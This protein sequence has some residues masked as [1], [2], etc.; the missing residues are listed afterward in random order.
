MRNIN[1]AVKD[2]AA[3]H[4]FLSPIVQYDD[5]VQYLPL[6][7]VGAA[8]LI[9]DNK[10]YPLGNRLIMAATA[11]GIELALV[12]A[13]K[14]SFGILRPDGSAH[15]A[16]PSGHTATAFMG[17]ELLRLSGAGGGVWLP[18]A[19]YAAAVFVGYSRIARNRHWFSDV[20]CGAAVGVLSA[21]A[22][23]LLYPYL[24]KAIFSAGKDYA[25]VIM[26]IASPQH[27]GASVA[28]RF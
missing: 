7:M 3:G 5:Y 9:V 26:P 18:V 6:A 10:K 25:F 1:D 24:H 20:L 11:A 16:F 23:W 13:M 15:N 27:T 17:A 21:Q 14:Y 22:A 8:A 4:N 12:N 28:L 2:A 19:G